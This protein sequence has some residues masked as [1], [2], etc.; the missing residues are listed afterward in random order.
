MNPTV[1]SPVTEEEWQAYYHFRWQVLRKPWNQPEGSEKDELENNAIHRMIVN[2]ENQVVAIGR[3]H[4]LDD[5]S[6]QIRYMAVAPDCE[7]NGLGTDILRALEEE[8]KR[9]QVKTIKLQSRESAVGFYKKF[10][11]RR[12][13]PGHLL[14]DCIQHFLMTKEL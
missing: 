4:F 3:I 2:H 1:T 11:Y 12:I 10:N 13:K 5:C 6:A 14:Y 7:K 8:A 9:R